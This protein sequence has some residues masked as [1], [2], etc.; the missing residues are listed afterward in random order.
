MSNKE[1]S[2]EYPQPEIDEELY[3]RILADRE[4]PPPKPIQRSTSSDNFGSQYSW[5]NKQL[6]ELSIDEAERIIDDPNVGVSTL[7]RLA[8]NRFDLPPND[9][10]YKGAIGALLRKLTDAVE[11]ERRRFP[12]FKI[13]SNEELAALSIDELEKL[14]NDKKTTTTTLERIGRIHFDI[15]PEKLWE[16]GYPGAIDQLNHIIFK[17]RAGELKPKVGLVAPKVKPKKCKGCDRVLMPEEKMALCSVCLA[18]DNERITPTQFATLSYLRTNYRPGMTKG[19]TPLYECKCENCMLNP[20]N[21]SLS[22]AM[23]FIYAHAGHHTICI[24]MN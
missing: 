7:V 8:T 15:R 19:S 2:T 10:W 21:L 23:N 24:N 20:R 3:A 16:T 13:L 14:I 17:V 22:L 18:L 12:T 9:A 6:A 5:S 11:D 1:A 4:P